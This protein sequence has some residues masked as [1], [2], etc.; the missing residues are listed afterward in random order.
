MA[1][2]DNWTFGYENMGLRGLKQKGIAAYLKKLA[3]RSP[4]YEWRHQ[5]FG[6]TNWVE[7]RR[8]K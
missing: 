3:K 4:S 2:D 8:K 5:R 6:K 7:Y 1:K